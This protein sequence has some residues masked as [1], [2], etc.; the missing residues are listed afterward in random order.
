MIAANESEFE[1]W[2]WGTQTLKLYPPSAWNSA[3]PSASHHS[4]NQ[5]R[6]RGGSEVVYEG[7]Y[8]SSLPERKK[9]TKEN[10]TPVRERGDDSSL[11]LFVTHSNIP[12]ALLFCRAG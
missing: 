4:V 6:A 10:Y 9:E 7:S 12:S 2:Y 5:V 8:H 1:M 11:P 3:P